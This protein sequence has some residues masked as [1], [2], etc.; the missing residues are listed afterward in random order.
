[1]KPMDI[2]KSNS[3]SSHQKALFAQCAIKR[4]ENPQKYACLRWLHAIP[5]GGA[6]DSTTAARMKAEGARAGVLDICLPFPNKQFHGLYIEMKAPG[7]IKNLSKEQEEFIEYLQ[8]V[9]YQTAVCDHWE[10]AWAT[11]EYYLR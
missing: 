7:K 8:S 10:G 9:G 11:I 5:N 4:L 6:R 3:E 1:M 2:A